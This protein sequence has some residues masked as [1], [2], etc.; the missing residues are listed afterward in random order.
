MV[1]NY[2]KY[3][4]RD[5]TSATRSKRWR[6]RQKVKR[7]GAS[8]RD[9][10]TLRRDDTQAEAYVQK[11]KQST[12]PTELAAAAVV[13]ETPRAREEP[14]QAI[15]LMAALKESLAAKGVGLPGVPPPPKVNQAARVGE[16]YLRTF[17][18]IGGRTIK[19]LTVQR[20]IVARVKKRL[21]EGLEP[22]LIV[23]LPILARVQGQESFEILTKTPTILLRDGKHGKTDGRGR[24]VGA[25]DHAREFAGRLDTFSLPPRLVKAAREVGVLA[26]LQA[27]GVELRTPRPNSNGAGG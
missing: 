22:E 18:A 5:H 26:W 8:R 10:V 13:E 24:T 1:L 4:D 11:Q 25:T 12:E 3:R 27:N 2:I 20:D 23:A 14:P 6:E 9:G 16:A 7:D 21:A 15:D 19:S 17:N